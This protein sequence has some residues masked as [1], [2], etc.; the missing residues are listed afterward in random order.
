MNG[1]TDTTFYQLLANKF[2]YLFELGL[3]WLGSSTDCSSNRANKWL[4]TSNDA[5][6]RIV[7]IFTFYKL[8]DLVQSLNLLVARIAWRI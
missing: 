8:N 3:A 6:G 4:D 2:K 5:V 1:D 7:N